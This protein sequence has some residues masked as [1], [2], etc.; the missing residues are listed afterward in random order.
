M[1]AA[2]SSSSEMPKF[3]VKKILIASLLL[4]VLVPGCLSAQNSARIIDWKL[5]AKVDFEDRYHEEYEAWYLFP[6]FSDKVKALDG[7]PVIIKG[8]IIPVDIEDGLYAL[9]AYP[10]SNCFFCGGA[11]PESVMS[12][13]FEEKPPHFDTDEVASFTGI[14]RLNDKNVDDFNYILEKAELVE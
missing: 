11:G 13:K 12:L 7:K 6:I 14:L 8:Y 9:S 3:M 4:S 5:L 10:F 2:C 1:A